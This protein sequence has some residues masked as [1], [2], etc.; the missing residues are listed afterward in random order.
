MVR[1]KEYVSKD[2]ML[3]MKEQGSCVIVS[4]AAIVAPIGIRNRAAYRE[5]RSAVTALTLAVALDRASDKL[6]ISCVAPALSTPSTS[7]TSSARMKCSKSGEVNWRPG[8]AMNQSEQ[9]EERSPTPLH[10]PEGG[11]SFFFARRNFYR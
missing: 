2:V 5:C 6:R 10:S 4:T 3:G 9:P 8:Q 1:R 7:K 11:R